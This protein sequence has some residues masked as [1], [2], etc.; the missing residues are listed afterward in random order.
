MCFYTGS[1]GDAA[2][3]VAKFLILQLK[4]MSQMGFFSSVD[5]MHNQKRPFIILPSH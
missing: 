2:F 4:N 1:Y 5:D 3:Y